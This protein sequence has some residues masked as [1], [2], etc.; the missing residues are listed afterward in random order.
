[1][2]QVDSPALPPGKE[3]ALA[4]FVPK[5]ATG[6][7]PIKGSFRLPVRPRHLVRPTIEGA[8]LDV[9]D[10]LARA[11]LPLTIVVTGERVPGPWL[12]P[13]RVAAH[14]A[15]G[16]DGLVVGHFA[17]DLLADG[18]LRVRTRQRYILYALAGE[19]FAGPYEVEWTP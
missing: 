13:L 11:V 6:G 5:R 8:P 7:L 15:P 19:A 18:G 16:P 1:V 9:G 17:L 4:L 2:K 3:P 14:Q 12:V 10:P